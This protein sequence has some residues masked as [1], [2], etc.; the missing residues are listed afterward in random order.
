MAAVRSGDLDMLSFV[1]AECKQ[2][3]KNNTEYRKMMRA[4]A[5]QIRKEAKVR[6]PMLADPASSL[7]STTSAAGQTSRGST[8]TGGVRLPLATGALGGSSSQ[9]SLLGRSGLPRT[10]GLQSLSRPGSSGSNS[11]LRPSSGH[12]GASLR[13]AG[14][15]ILGGSRPL[16]DK[17]RHSNSR[18]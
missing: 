3:A 18:F 4:T 15:A 5:A 7:P 14:G 16:E 12:R 10:T 13:Q 1:Q 17:S 11:G 9:A 6:Y 2:V 8:P